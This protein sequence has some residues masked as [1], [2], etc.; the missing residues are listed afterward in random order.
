[1]KRTLFLNFRPTFL[2][3]PNLRPSQ[4]CQ[5][6]VSDEAKFWGK[7]RP[8]FRVYRF[9]KMLP[10]T[11]VRKT[12]WDLWKVT[13]NDLI[14]ANWY[15]TCA[16]QQDHLWLLLFQHMN[17]NDITS[18][19]VSEWNITFLLHVGYL[20]FWLIMMI[21]LHVRKCNSIKHR[22]LYTSSR[23]RWASSWHLTTGNEYCSV[24][25]L[26]SYNCIMCQQVFWL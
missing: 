7:A 3:R 20:I 17:P 1:M 21:E 13:I 8:G 15:R 22:H 11:P 10:I 24:K 25:V 18:D 2:K 23:F 16:D 6:R 4:K 26:S 5:A 19:W 14:T 12:V 9:S